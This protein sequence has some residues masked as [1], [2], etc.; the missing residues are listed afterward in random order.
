MKTKRGLLSFWNLLLVVES[1]LSSS[2]ALTLSTRRQ[3]VHR[4][5][6]AACWATT[7]RADK[8]ALAIGEGQ[9]RMVLTQKPH[10]PTAALL[11][12]VQQRLLLEKCLVLAS[13]LQ[14]T[15]TAPPQQQQAE[16]LCQLKTILL[17][18]NDDD[19]DAAKRRVSKNN[20][21]LNVMLQHSPA[22]V[23][24]GALVRAAMNI[25]TSNLSDNNNK[26]SAEY[27]VTDPTWKKQYI[28]ANNGLP[29]V[30][31]VITADLNV[32]DLYRNAVQLAL[33]DAA[34]ELYNNNGS[35]VL[36][37]KSLLRDAAVNFDLWL[38]R[39][40]DKDVQDALQMAMEGKTLQVYESY[41]AGFV[42]P[43]R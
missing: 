27:N 20:K 15:D 10:A 14:T 2:W 33:D 11:S 41:T 28:R 18:L 12:A 30:Q 36:E 5:A 9:E 38:D 6:A 16:I 7:C 24:S 8:S 29:P 35:D 32:R 40:S 43:Q 37:L 23:M 31:R 39:I 25:Y 13:Q 21:D 26:E 42:P 22:Q 1:L 17:P 19:D 4:A 3:V 34:A